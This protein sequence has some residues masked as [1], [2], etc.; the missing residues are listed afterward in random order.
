MFS[1]RY[2]SRMSHGNR[3][4]S[5]ALCCSWAFSCA[6]TTMAQSTHY[7]VKLA[8]DFEHQLLKG[9]ETIEVQADAGEVEW[10][11]Q[12]GLRVMSANVADGDVTVNEQAVRVRLRSGGKHILRVKYTAT[13]GRGI[14][15][16]GSAVPRRDYSRDSGFA[17]AFYCE[18]WI[19]CNTSP[20]QRATLRLEIVIPSREGGNMG[21]RAVGPGTRGREWRARDGDH[22]V[23]EQSDP[24]QTYLFSFG[25]A[26]LAVAVNGKFSIYAQKMEASKE[27]FAKTEDAYAF[28]RSIASI[29]PM[30]SHYAQVFLPGPSM[31][32]EAAG[33]ALLSQDNMADLVDKDDVKLMAHELAHQWWGVTVGIQSWSDFWLN[34]G[35]AEFMSIAY[36]ERHQGRAAY[37]QQIAELRD[38][39]K[40]L[41][42]EGKDRPLHWEKWKDSHEA[43]GQIPYVKG[44]LFLARLRTE[45][46]D[47]IFWRGIGLYTSANA[48]RLV[49]S[50]DFERAMEKANGRDLKALFD[51][52]VYR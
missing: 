45:L 43:L 8:P 5:I 2:T 28:L 50:R 3:F 32:Q 9:D 21:F 39:M 14:R 41:R 22:F 7:S 48:R 19:V 38:R 18:A 52:A 16:F 44:A 12:A 46:G 27:A 42:E 33:M 6:A 35:F 36:I 4:R 37:D 15:W 24:V 31:G 17:T 20:G 25:V 49:D 34:E 1:P 26:R 13:A 51:E 11:K 10:Q 40:K 23:F 47:E 29:D 30:N